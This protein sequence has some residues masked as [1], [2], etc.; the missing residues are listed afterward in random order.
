MTSY[1]G[2][3]KSLLLQMAHW[4]TVRKKDVGLTGWV[5]TPFDP[6]PGV[7]V[8]Q[9]HSCPVMLQS[10]TLAWNFPL[11]ISEAPNLIKLMPVL[12][13]LGGAAVAVHP[14]LQGDV[15]AFTRGAAEERMGR[16]R[17]AHPGGG[18]RRRATS[19]EGNHIWI[20]SP[21]LLQWVPGNRQRYQNWQDPGGRWGD[22]YECDRVRVCFSARMWARVFS[23]LHNFMCTACMRASV[24]QLFT[25]GRGED[26]AML[27][28]GIFRHA[29]VDV[30]LFK[31]PYGN[32]YTT[33]LYKCCT[34]FIGCGCDGYLVKRLQLL[35]R[36][37]QLVGMWM[38]YVWGC[39][40]P[41]LLGSPLFPLLSIIVFGAPNMLIRS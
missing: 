3:H 26:Y 23:C 13:S 36:I 16:V 18:Q 29:G 27:K 41:S 8:A 6:A 10:I 14:G 24:Q 1:C 12:I 9:V 39:F 33:F 38:F 21:S 35:S 17:G 37:E 4:E 15:Q 11:I 34:N 32:P 30:Q 25:P 20:Q 5:S 2:L 40:D 28:C 31:G 19:P 22:V 7:L